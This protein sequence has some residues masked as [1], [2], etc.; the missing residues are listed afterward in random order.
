MIDKPLSDLPAV[1][2][3]PAPEDAVS[4]VCF[5]SDSSSLLVSTWAGTLSVFA[6]QTGALRAEAKR[7]SSA[8]LDANWR[9]EVPTVLAAS[10]DGSLLH[11]TFTE[12]SVTNWDVVG[13]HEA[14]IRAFVPSVGTSAAIVTGGWDKTIRLWDLRCDAKSNMLTNMQ[15]NGK[16]F[17]AASCGPECAIFITSQRRVCVLDI[18]NTS[19][20]LHDREPPTLAHQLRGISVTPD[21][22]QYVVGS[23]EGRVAVEW[24]DNSGKDSFSF[25]CHRLDGLAFPVNCVAHN[26]R[27]GS[28]ATGG[29]DG[30][31]AV[32][33]GE[34]RKRIAQFS[35]YPTSVASIDFDP[36]SELLAVAVSYAF[37]EGEK[38]HPPDE[39]LIRKVDDSHIAT[40]RSK[41]KRK[42]DESES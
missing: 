3:D 4:C 32:W 1:T 26:K 41:L 42:L 21:G 2:V 19:S 8:L 25:R 20:F 23:T 17:G 29:G 10:L 9:P 18:R 16:I 36:Q 27:Y 34:A 37:E 5:S 14:A 7:H 15:A 13:R 22:S 6:P 35:R 38:D 28:F 12:A 40:K 31:V 30:H 11:A 33:D 24:L 39:V